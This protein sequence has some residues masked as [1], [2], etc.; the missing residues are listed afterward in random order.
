MRYNT[1]SLKVLILLYYSSK[2]TF[3]LR[4]IFKSCIINSI[5]NNNNKNIIAKLLE[6]N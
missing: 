5:N 4:Y 1:K 2:L 6:Y 3:K